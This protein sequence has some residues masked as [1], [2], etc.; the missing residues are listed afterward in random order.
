[1][2]YYANLTF[3]AT[4]EID[5]VGNIIRD[6]PDLSSDYYEYMHKW[7]VDLITLNPEH[8]EVL[9]GVLESF[10]MSFSP[11]EGAAPFDEEYIEDHVESILTKLN[12]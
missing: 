10:Y 9:A 5:D 3:S 12:S 1:M 2:T 4:D 8:K 11:I 7:F 6:M